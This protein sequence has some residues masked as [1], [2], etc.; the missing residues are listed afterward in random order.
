MAIDDEIAVKA[1]MD[2]FQE[3]D[4]K[5]WKKI[6]A[7]IKGFKKPARVD[8][9]GKFSVTSSKWDKR[10]LEAQARAIFRYDLSLYAS[11]VWQAFTPIEKAKNDKDKK[12]ATS[13]FT[14]ILPKLLKA[15]V[16]NMNEKFV[17]FQEDIAS[18]AGDDLGQLKATRKSLTAGI[19]GDMTGIAT[20]FADEV[21]RVID[22][23]LALK[24]QEQKSSGAAKT[25]ATQKLEDEIK[26]ALP[27]LKTGLVQQTSALKKR[28]AVLIG[29]PVA[30]KKGLNKDISD[31]AKAEFKKS[32][33]AL[34][35]ATKPMNTFVAKF[36]KD[37][38]EVFKRI[39]RKDIGS[40]LGKQIQSAVD[41]VMNY[42][43]KLEELMDKIDARLK[44]LEQAAKS[45]K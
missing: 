34:A 16:K 11:Q 25:E 21:V 35:K 44:K 28:A 5:K 8:I 27:K 22:G 42:F 31:A 17:E 7:D 19:A 10:K 3:F 9:S 20:D 41:K 40:S 29:I 18:G 39:Q 6:E 30:I 4:K 24:K 38:L 12:K 23:L 1:S 43:G 26:D 36:D 33:D 45:R 13:D 2:P 15:L 32:M 14:K 37:M